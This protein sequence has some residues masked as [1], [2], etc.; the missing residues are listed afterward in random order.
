[1]FKLNKVMAIILVSLIL[2]TSC[3]RRVY[4]N[5]SRKISVSK[6]QHRSPRN[7]RGAGSDF[8]YALLITVPNAILF[9][10]LMAA[11]EN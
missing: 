8:W 2:M 4:L 5:E 9:G 10:K 11:D 6:K 7:D 3:G 1:M